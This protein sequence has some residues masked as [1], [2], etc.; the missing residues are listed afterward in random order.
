M[1][2][3]FFLFT[4]VSRLFGDVGDE[5]IETGKGLNELTTA[6]YLAIIAPL[7]P[8]DPYILEAGAHSGE[9]TILIAQK[10]P[11]GR[12]FAFEPVPHF[13]ERIIQ[14][15]ES[16]HISNVD[17]FPIG[18]FSTSG[19]RT[20]YYSQNCGGASSYLPD[21]KL[22]ETNYNDIKLTLPCVN[23]DDWALKQG[24]D[25]IDFMWLDME[26]AEYYVLSTA[27]EILKTTKVIITELNFRSFREGTTLYETLK[28]FL[29][30]MGFTL[31]LVWGSATW[32]GTGLFVKT[33]LLNSLIE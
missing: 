28:P 22:P 17:A 3:L 21:G 8:P 31:H 20:F 24:I 15:L 13:F 25:H 27:P 30:S 5:F 11:T 23:L 14:N 6:E 19:D 16:K 18:L 26:G 2:V 29:E 33:E 12:I 4:F 32:Q 1:V 10:W 9:D 7:L